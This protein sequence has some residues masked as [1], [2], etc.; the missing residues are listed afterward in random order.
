MK[1]PQALTLTGALL[2]VGAT[3]AYLWETSQE[4]VAAE[5]QQVIS[6]APAPKEEFRDVACP[7]PQEITERPQLE[8]HS[9]Y[10]PTL[11]VGAKFSPSDTLPAESVSSD[12]IIYA[13]SE[14]IESPP[15]EFPC[16]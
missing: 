9:W 6:S 11:G 15:K 10:S 5:P 7:I 2:I 3:S 12:G 16:S 1:T 13:P 8:A 14:A 4:P